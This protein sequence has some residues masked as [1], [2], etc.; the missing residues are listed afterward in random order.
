[1]VHRFLANLQINNFYPC[2][3]VTNTVSKP[4]GESRSIMVSS[5]YSPALLQFRF[6]LAAQVCVFTIRI[7]LTST[8]YLPQID[9]GWNRILHDSPE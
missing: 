1:M 4:H 8:A 9:R 2:N 6:G 3:R 5:S 7:P